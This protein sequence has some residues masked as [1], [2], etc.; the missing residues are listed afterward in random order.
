[1]ASQQRESGHAIVVELVRFLPVVLDV[2]GL[3]LLAFLALVRLVVILLVTRD[4]IFLQLVLVQVAFMAVRTLGLL[5]LAQK[6]IL[7]L[8]IVVELDCLPVISNVTGIALDT[9]VTLVRF[10]IVFLVT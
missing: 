8:L 7:G 3:T 1:M 6:R 10:V 2:A 9:E 4:A 5:M